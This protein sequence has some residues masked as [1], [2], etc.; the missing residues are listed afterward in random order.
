MK[1]LDITTSPPTTLFSWNGT[2]HIGLDET[3]VHIDNTPIDELC[4]DE[5]KWD[6]Q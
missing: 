3:R 5:T 2:N 6:I 1:Y 4:T